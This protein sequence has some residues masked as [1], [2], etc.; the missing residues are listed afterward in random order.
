[1]TNLIRRAAV[2]A[3][4]VMGAVAAPAPAA[5]VASKAGPVNVESLAKLDNPWGMTFLPDGRLLV[6]E[7]P[8]RL[9]V[10]ADGKLSEPIGGVPKVAYK[11]QGGLLD[12]E[13]DPNFAQNK[14]VYLSFAES[15]E[16]QPA[17]A[18]DEIDARLGPWFKADDPELRGGA[19][20]RGRLEGNQ[21]ADVK[22]IWRQVPKTLGRGHYGGRLVFAPDGKLF[23]ASGERQRFEPAQ[24]SATNLGAMV[25]INPDGSIPTD[26]PF[27]GKPGARPDLWTVGNRNPLGAAIDPA[28]K[29][30]WVNEMGP[31]GG[32]ELNLI[33][34]G[35]NYGWPAVADGVHYDDSPI[36]RHATRPEFAAPAYVWNPVISPSGMAFYSGSM[37]PSWRGSA[38]IGGLSS[39]AVVR[40]TIDGEKASEAERL[41][42]GKRIRD[43]AEAPDGAVLLLSDGAQGEL[44]RLTPAKAGAK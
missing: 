41:E 5:E 30:L 18:K 39:K 13:I 31:K 8:G 1:M 35:R 33:L 28:T 38:L 26:N 34:P 29:Q 23:I 17:G 43:V 22:V 24:D 10:F 15:A 40:A 19:V 20:A 32:D 4:A 37:F 6:T 14:F 7:K 36:P 3:V 44:L 25:R 2:A 11:G 27:A 12:V 9:R 21:L 42:M 16:A